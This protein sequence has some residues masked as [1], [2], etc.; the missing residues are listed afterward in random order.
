MQAQ[1]TCGGSLSGADA[2]QLMGEYSF[3]MALIGFLAEKQLSV[4]DTNLP[5][6][7]QKNGTKINTKARNF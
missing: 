6:N 1:D 2:N 3:L 4:R 5:G 7:K